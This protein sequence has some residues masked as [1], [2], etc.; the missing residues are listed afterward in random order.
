MKKRRRYSVRLHFRRP[1]RLGFGLWSFA[2][3][4]PWQRISEDPE[5]SEPGKAM[6]RGGRGNR[7]C[8]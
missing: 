1:T 4:S 5:C 2:R 8:S 3:A 7:T 6:W